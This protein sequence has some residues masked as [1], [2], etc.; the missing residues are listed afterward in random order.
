MRYR[1]N[2]PNHHAYE[3]YGGRGITVCSRWDNFENFLQDMGP[4]P[5]LEY[6]LDRIENNG[7]YEPNNCKWATALEQ[8]HN[9]RDVIQSCRVARILRDL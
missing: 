8:R 2:N 6:T 9:R 5:S 1:C 3:N 4:R 7:N